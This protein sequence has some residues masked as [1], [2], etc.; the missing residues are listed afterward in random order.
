MTAAP[1]T[2]EDRKRILLFCCSC[3]A[4]DH[5]GGSFGAGVSADYCFNCG[6]GPCFPLPLWA[7]EEVRRN[8]SFVGRLYYPSE[9]DRERE[10]ELKA[11]RE[12]IKEHP[13]RTVHRWV[14]D[15]FDG[16]AYWVIE[17]Q[18]SARS[19]TSIMVAVEKAPTEADALEWARSRLPYVPP[20]TTE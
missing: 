7:I 16:A 11:L 19:R 17:Q 20:T 3:F 2:A 10:A 4:A 8:A 1:A 6:A 14:D 12:T 13:G 5:D 15:R 9:Q 18:T